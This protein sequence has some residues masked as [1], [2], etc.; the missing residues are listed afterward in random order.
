MLSSQHLKGKISQTKVLIFPQ[1][2]SSPVFPTSVNG[3]TKVAKAET[4][5]IIHDSP[6]SFILHG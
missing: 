6:L 1:S 4:F 5:G 3:I 2:Y